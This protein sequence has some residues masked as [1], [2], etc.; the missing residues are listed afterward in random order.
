MQRINLLSIKFWLRGEACLARGIINKEI[1]NG[2][3]LPCPDEICQRECGTIEPSNI[4]EQWCQ[5]EKT[6]K[7][8]EEI[9]KFRMNLTTLLGV[10]I[11]SYTACYSKDLLFHSGTLIGAIIVP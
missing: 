9:N 4:V 2:H 10:V 6:D 3:C 1:V 7:I 8:Q 5:K 11:D